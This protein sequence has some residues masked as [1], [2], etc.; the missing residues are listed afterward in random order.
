HLPLLV[1]ELVLDDADAHA[2]EPVETAHPLRVAPRQVV[3]DGDHVNALAFE[4][5]QVGRQRGNERFAFARFHFGDLAGVQHHAAAELYV[6]VP[7]VEH[8]AS[9]FAYDSERFGEQ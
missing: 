3:V 2:Q 9:G 6:E 8:A 7:H 5:V 1:G 4:C